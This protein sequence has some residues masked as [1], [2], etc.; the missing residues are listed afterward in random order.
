[1][2]SKI[3]SFISFAITI[4]FFA[5]WGVIFLF[6]LPS[7][8]PPNGLSNT[9]PG[10]TRFF[11]Q[12]WSLFSPPAAYDFR[13]YFILRDTD[14]KSI[15]DTME[16]LENIS[17]QKQ[18][19]APFNQREILTDQM[20]YLN[21]KKLNAA[22]LKTVYSLQSALPDSSDNYC[23]AESIRVLLNNHS[24]TDYITNL[25]NYSRLLYKMNNTVI[26]DKEQKMILARKS[27]KP[28]KQ[29]AGKSFIPAETIIF[30]TMYA[31]VN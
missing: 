3:Y 1:M 20:I 9:A 17:L 16:V 22:L 23:R 12:E 10:L 13:L 15:A 21:I 18:R 19:K 29:A 8:K 26:T 25:E 6:A 4:V 31:P 27:I 7:N 30:E 24:C 2:K 11:Y 28:F 14:K 5:Y